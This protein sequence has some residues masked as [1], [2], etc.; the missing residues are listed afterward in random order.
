MALVVKNPPAST[1]DVRCGFD[2]WVRKIPGGGNSNPLQYSRL[3][4]PRGRVA[5][6]A[7]VHGV[8]KSWARLKRRSTFKFSSAAYCPAPRGT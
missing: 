5:W 3:E 4:N 2:S 8:A 6:G 1:G 7:I